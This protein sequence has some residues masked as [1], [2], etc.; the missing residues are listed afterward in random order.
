MLDIDRKKKP[1][2]RTYEI[3]PSFLKSYL[4]EYR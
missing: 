2:A 3:N 1:E 4:L